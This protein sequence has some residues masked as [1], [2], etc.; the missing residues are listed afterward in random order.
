LIFVPG[1]E[2]EVIFVLMEANYQGKKSFFILGRIAKSTTISFKV[3]QLRAK[4]I[5]FNRLSLHYNYF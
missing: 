3:I 2:K 4:L 5:L 1:V